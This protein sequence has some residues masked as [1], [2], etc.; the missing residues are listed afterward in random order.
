[1]G[2]DFEP[3]A[4]ARNP[5]KYGKFPFFCW[6]FEPFRLDGSK[7]EQK[8]GNFL[9]FCSDFEPWFENRTIWHPNSF[10]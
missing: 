6:D 9:F 1:M 10:P 7:S 2:S 5:N 3:L 4:M 8:I